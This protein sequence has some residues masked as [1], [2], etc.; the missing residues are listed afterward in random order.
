[1]ALQT[2]LLCF[3]ALTASVRGQRQSDAHFISI[4]CGIDPDGGYRDSNTQIAYSSDAGYIDTGVN[5]R[6][7]SDYNMG[8]LGRRYYDL[9][10]F[11]NGTRNCYTLSPLQRGKKY[12]VRAGFVYGNYDGLNQPPELDL[13]LGVNFWQTVFANVTG[14]EIMA[15]IPDDFVH[16]CLVNT[17][18]GTPFISAL[19]LR[20]LG[21]SMYPFVNASQSLVLLGDR[22]NYGGNPDVQIRYPDDPYDR[23][24][25]TAQNGKSWLPVS[26][27]GAEVKTESDDMFLVPS[28]VMGTAVTTASLSAGL[29]FTVTS[30]SRDRFYLIMHFAELRRLGTNESNAFDVNKNGA[31]AYQ[32]YVPKYLQ[33]GQLYTKEPGSEGASTTYSLVAT[34]N[35]TVAPI[36]NA[37]EVHY[38][39]RISLLPTDDRDGEF[40]AAFLGFDSLKKEITP[41]CMNDTV[42]AMLSIKRLYQ[43]GKNNWEGDPC[44]PKKFMWEDL[45]CSYDA[46]MSPRIISLNLSSSGLTGGIPDS[47]VNLTALESLDLSCN[48]FT[49][50]IPGFLAEL[51]ALHFLN[52]SRNQLSG[53]VPQG[54]DKKSQNGSL[55]L[56]VNGNPNLCEK[57]GSCEVVKQGK[58]I[59]V[60]II[61]AASAS[62]LLL[63]LLLF[64]FTWVFKRIRRR[65]ALQ[66]NPQAQ[67]LD[68]SANQRGLDVE[69]LQPESCQFTFSEIAVITNNFERVIGKGG[70][71]TV[72]LGYLPDGTQVAVKTL[73]EASPHGA[74]QFLAEAIVSFHVQAQVLTRVH[75]KNLVS[76]LGYCNDENN[77]ALVYEFMPQ[78]SLDKHLSGFLTDHSQ[79]RQN[80]FFLSHNLLFTNC[81]CSIHSML[82]CNNWA[83]AQLHKV[84]SSLTNISSLPFY[85]PYEFCWFT[86]LDY[87]HSGCNPPIVHRD[88]KATNILLDKNLGAKLADF[89]LSKVFANQDATHVTTAVAGTLGYLDPEYVFYWH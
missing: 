48:N 21:D 75:H 1:M 66:T 5:K 63:L 35:S 62:L 73:S 16:V 29:S 41:V 12:L 49:G 76:F 89:G 74:K 20:P 6:V 25:F 88:V 78:G 86:R 32:G 46:S 65:D 71:G 7:S 13:Y 56:S 44:A 59:P 42:N 34:A 22:L 2:L 82:V 36:L 80:F 11:P 57:V 77:L 45:N 4:D 18:A 19:E 54:L 47:I 15:L 43:V 40:I 53:I 14:V 33:A 30:S 50:E 28:A 64:T 8:N 27:E 3:I 61:I 60:L 39:R 31:L 72:Y 26:A 68:I 85:L 52:L 84:T 17:G 38:L 87:L 70:F 69:N 67:V 10:S 23:V 83:H 24:W 37:L 51:P 81:L 58:K 55:L 9:R 79:N